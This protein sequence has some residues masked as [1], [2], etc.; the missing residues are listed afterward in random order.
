MHPIRLLLLTFDFLFLTDIINL[1][2]KFLVVNF[3]FREEVIHIS[4]ETFF[5]E[6]LVRD[7]LYLTF[8]RTDT[9]S[10]DFSQTKRETVKGRLCRVLTDSH[11]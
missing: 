4:Q 9:L 7:F 5:E 1:P 11:L 3:T 2:L 10:F 6:T 8:L